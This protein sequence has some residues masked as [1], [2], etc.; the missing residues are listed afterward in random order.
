MLQVLTPDEQA[1][2]AGDPALHYKANLIALS[3]HESL[4]FV[5]LHETI[6]VDRPNSAAHPL[7]ADTVSDIRWKLPVTPEAASATHHHMSRYPHG[8]NR[9]EVGFLG[10]QEVVACVCDD[11]DV[12]SELRTMA[13]LKLSRSKSGFKFVG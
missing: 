3:Q 13:T 8:V 6:Y 5:A 7:V 1:A 10:D 12:V 2:W 9:L 11:G 4:Y